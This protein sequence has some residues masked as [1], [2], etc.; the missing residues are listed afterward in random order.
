VA[1]TGRRVGAPPTAK[2]ISFSETSARL[3]LVYVFVQRLDGVTATSL[4]ERGSY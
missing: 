4:E 1:D 2:F 3:S